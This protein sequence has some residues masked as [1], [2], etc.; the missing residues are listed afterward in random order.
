MCCDIVALFK[1]EYDVVELFIEKGL[2]IIDEILFEKMTKN[3][4]TEKE[5]TFCD[6]YLKR[7]D[8]HGVEVD[9][10]VGWSDATAYEV[11]TLYL[12]NPLC[13][14]HINMELDKKRVR[15]RLP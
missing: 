14:R 12:L 7:Y 6:A 11:A 8:F 3:K 13:Q 5:K 15:S 10:D 9:K 2:S 1:N 4:M